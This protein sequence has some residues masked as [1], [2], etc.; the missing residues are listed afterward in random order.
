[1]FHA[2]GTG[3]RS[4]EKLVDSGMIVAVLDMTTTEVADHIVG[5]VFSAGLDRLGA[6]ARTGLPYV[7][8]VGAVDMVNFGALDT[9]P[10][11]FA[12]R[13]LHVH[14]PQV[15]L[16]RTTPEENTLIG[17]FIAA[18]LNRC[19]GPVRFLLPEGGVSMIDA[20]GQPFHDPL[21]DD[22]LFSAIEQGVVQTEHRRVSRVDA[23]INDEAFATAV[24]AA[25]DD[26]MAA[27]SPEPT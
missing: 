3:G 5:G 21:A 2:T 16:M 9:V 1:V 19:D 24:L 7:G 6:I 27:S 12:E 4:M 23:N 15:T 18:K 26:V 20:P 8:S 13:N 11:R 22:A 25:F 17:E 10:S 14:N